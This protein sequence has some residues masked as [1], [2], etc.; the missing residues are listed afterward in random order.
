[1][2]PA[3]GVADGVDGERFELGLRVH[4]PRAFWCRTRVRDSVDPVSVE[5]LPEQ[6]A[7]IERPVDEPGLLAAGPGTGKTWVL[8][9]RCEH[10][11]QNGVG[12]DAI[13][14]VTLTRSLAADLTSRMPHGRAS[15]LHSFALGH[16]NRLREAWGHRVV[17]PWEQRTLVQEDLVTGYELTFN[18]KVGG[19]PAAKRFLLKMSRAFRDAQTDPAD[20]TP[21]EMGLHQVFLDQ[22]DLFGYRLMDE[23]ANDLANLID[24]GHTPVR[25]E[26][27]VLVDEYQDL[28]AGELRL[29]QLMWERCG[30]QINACGDDRQSIYNFREADER[31]LH[32]FD[33]VYKLDKVNYLWRSRRCP[34]RVCKLANEIALALPPLPGIERPHLEPWPG[35][36]DTGTVELRTFRS[37]KVEAESVVDRCIA[38][39]AANV[40][41]EE[42][43]VVVANF[44]AP[45]FAALQDAAAAAQRPELF[46]DPRV[47]SRAT[48]L[49]EVRLVLAGMRLLIDGSDQMAWRTLVWG[50]ARVGPG[51]RRKILEANGSTYFKRLEAVAGFDARVA[52]PL[53]AG[54]AVLAQFSGQDEV[55][56]LAMLSLLAEKLA[57]TVD[58]A[59]LGLVAT[60]SVAPA[61]FARRVFEQAEA[62]EEA[63]AEPG[64]VRD[65]AIAVHTVHSAK[66]LEARHVFV[67]NAINESFIRGGAGDGIRRAFVAVSRASEALYMSAPR[68][69]GYTALAGKIGGGVTVTRMA[70]LLKHAA[71]RCDISVIVDR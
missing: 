28:T 8:E 13:A 24:D 22:R 46:Y 43:V 29:L 67:V 6:R 18:A 12:S 33:D 37:S 25:C 16:L 64:V 32:R 51:S 44:Y 38:F 31:A 56:P 5:P 63:E 36:A 62:E 1:M 65:D 59:V 35:R 41:A 34:E 7:F 42:V 9:R 55:D 60:T 23:L 4:S 68:F 19:Q 39:L 20:L 21:K 30:T 57:R 47:G 45:V 15:T 17:D 70:D 2:V 49:P 50:A 53:D 58:A 11:V 40:K 10:L 71:G 66:G 61:E 52:Q 69:V 27:H 3:F 54:K 14:T 48:D 26:T